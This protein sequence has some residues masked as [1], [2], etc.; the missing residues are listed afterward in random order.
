MNYRLEEL[1]SGTFEKLINSICQN[2]LGI[3]VISFA[4]GKDGGRDGIFEGIAAKYPDEK[5]SWK[6]KFIIQAKHTSNPIASCSDR[7]FEPVIIDKEIIKLK[8]LRAANDVDCYLIF[9]NRKYTGLIGE[10]IRKRIIKETLIPNV[11]ILGSETINNQYLNPNKELVRLYGLDKLHIPFDFSDEE[12]KELIIQFK[13]QLPT[14]KNDIAAQVDKIKYEFNRI[15]LSE[16]NILNGLGEE[17][18]K[19]EVLGRSL[20][21]FDKIQSFLENPINEEIKEQYF[22]IAAELSQIITLKRSNFDAFEEIFVFIYQLICDGEISVKGAK[23]HVTTLL[24]YMYFECLIG[25]K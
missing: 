7:E 17:Y 25:K 23:R 10:A 6:G 24:H 9:T 16:K 1:D 11:A 4:E 8:K 14:I 22:D 19:N 13:N 18:Y 20:S 2:I 15:K 12:I 5:N 21:D 3:G